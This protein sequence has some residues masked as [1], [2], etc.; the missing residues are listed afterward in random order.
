MKDSKKFW[1]IINL[2]EIYVTN[3][4]MQFYLNKKEYNRL[5]K[6]FRSIKLMNNLKY[7]GKTYKI[8]IK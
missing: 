6:Y 1:K 5:I 8:R 4:K 2:L 3:K 7:H